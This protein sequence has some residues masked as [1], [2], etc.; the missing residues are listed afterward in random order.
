M[1]W[2][3]LNELELPSQERTKKVIVRL[4]HLI[5][6]NGWEFMAMWMSSQIHHIRLNPHEKKQLFSS[7]FQI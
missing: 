6:I 1:N 5:Q 4:S 3:R 7:N 2:S